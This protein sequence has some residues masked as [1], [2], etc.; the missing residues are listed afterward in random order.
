MTARTVQAPRTSDPLDVPFKQLTVRSLGAPRL[1]PR[2]AIERIKGEFVEM[3]GFS[4][5]LD[6]AARLF[7]LQKEECARLLTALLHEGFLQQSPDGRYRLTA[8]R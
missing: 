4:P 2:E 1:V 5:T 8:A 6:Q 7:N 3:R